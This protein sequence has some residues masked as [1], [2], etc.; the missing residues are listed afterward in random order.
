MERVKINLGGTKGLKRGL[1]VS[2]N[3]MML[4]LVYVSH[5]HSYV[6]VIPYNFGE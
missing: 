4:R 3:D 5:K 6:Y 1:V 2:I